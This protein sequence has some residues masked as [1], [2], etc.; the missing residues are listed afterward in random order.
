[1]ERHRYRLELRRDRVGLKVGRAIYSGHNLLAAGT[2]GSL[3][4]RARKLKSLAEPLEGC[5]EGRR[6]A[7]GSKLMGLPEGFQCQEPLGGLIP[8]RRR[9][10]LSGRPLQQ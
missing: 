6:V 5:R 8:I 3:L 7:A 10:I 2:A 4:R 9:E 1:M